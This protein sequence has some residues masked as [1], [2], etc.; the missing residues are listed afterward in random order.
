LSTYPRLPGV[1]RWD[2]HVAREV[3]RQARIEAA[4]DRADACDLFGDS[5]HALHWLDRAAALAGGL[6]PGYRARHARLARRLADTTG[7]L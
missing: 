4:F 1:S 7:S 3:E 5:A 6:P 2:E